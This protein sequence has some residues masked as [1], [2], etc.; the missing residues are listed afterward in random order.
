MK[1]TLTQFF[2]PLARAARP[3]GRLPHSGSEPPSDPKRDKPAWARRV[4]DAGC[5][6]FTNT[7]HH[8]TSV[9]A[10]AGVLFLLLCG[11]VTDVRAQLVISD[12]NQIVGTIKWINDPAGPVYGYL[13]SAAPPH[14][15]GSGP[16]YARQVGGGFSA[17]TFVPD[18][19]SHIS[20]PYSITVQAGITPGIQYD[21]TP[22]MTLEDNRVYYFATATSSG[23]L[24]EPAPDVV[25]DFAECAGLIEVQFCDSANNPVT[26]Q[27]GS[28]YAYVQPFGPEAIQAHGVWGSVSSTRF[29]VRGGNTFSVDVN[30]DE[31]SGTDPFFDYFSITYSAN[32]TVTVGCEEIVVLKFIV[33]PS[34]S[35]SGS[36]LGKIVG[37]VDMLGE[38]EH[39]IDRVFT[40]LRADD[41]PLGNYRYDS[42]EPASL[43]G[44]SSGPFSLVN[45]LPSNFS[46]PARDYRVRGELSF[47]SNRRYEFFQTPWLD[48]DNGRVTVPPGA[49]VDLGD[50]FV[51]NPGYVV[52]D[53]FLC[54]PDEE[55]RANSL[56]RHIYRGSDSDSNGDGIPDDFTDLRGSS[57]VIADG[58][59]LLGAGATR[60]ARGGYAQALFEGDFVVSGPDK[61]HFVGDY[62][63][64]LGGLLQETTRWNPQG[65]VLFFSNTATPA[66]RDTYID[67]YVQIVDLPF[68]N[69]EIVPGQTLRND[70][71]YGFSQVTVRF[72]ATS[73]TLF[74]PAVTALGSFNGVNFAMVTIFSCSIDSQL[75]TSLLVFHT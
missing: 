15:L 54:G 10:W 71:R 43:G 24:P 45:L 8:A 9:A 50:T 4:A 41:G 65:L 21:V 56:L 35:G 29:A 51:I 28:F 53:I 26:V 73:G 75:V 2:T 55:G 30:I 37:N 46:V 14:G 60:T 62:R 57:R 61:N 33:P 69:Q 5:R 7:T 39:W 74:Q 32:Y 68:A 36:A 18:D 67:L 11:S 58:L 49:T 23:V 12:P 31:T 17:G 34:L 16:L 52:G 70:H 40:L 19:A 64:T 72:R 47:G 59:D 3:G 27:S 63:L 66:D 1:I 22:R 13:N 44:P 38:S 42:V 48:R 20:V 25:L 6:R